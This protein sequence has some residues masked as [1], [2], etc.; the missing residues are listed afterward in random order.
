MATDQKVSPLSTDPNFHA[1]VIENELPAYR[2]ISRL[3]IF[4]LG[5]GFISLFCWAH[6]VF[7]LASIFAVVL[8]ILAHRSIKKFPDMLT[9]QGLASA[10]IAIGLIFGLGSATFDLVQTFVR[11]QMAGRF[12][13]TYAETLE[14]GSLA[15]VLGMHLPPASRKDMTGAQFQKQIETASSKDKMMMDQKFGPLFSLRKRVGLSKEQHFEFV[16]IESVGEDDS[17]G[18]QIPI[19]ALALFEMHGPTTKDYPE[20]KEFALAILK[21]VV[22]GKQYEWWVD[23]IRYPYTPRTYVAPVAAPDD[24]HGHAH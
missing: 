4:S 6:P 1:S 5:C 15:D 11:T 21:G 20:A 16:R 9:G 17:R 23:D 7:Y 18:A 3:A 22:V 13:K 2:A 10:G 14:A 12:A 19:I 24:G 8:G